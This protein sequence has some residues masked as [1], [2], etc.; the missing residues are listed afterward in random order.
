MW[1]P[2]LRLRIDGACGDRK[3]NRCPDGAGRPVDD[4]AC[5][6]QHGLGPLTDLTAVA[7]EDGFRIALEDRLQRAAQLHG[8]DLAGLARSQCLPLGRA[9]VARA[10]DFPQP[11]SVFVGDACAGHER[12]GGRLCIC[13]RR[14]DEPAFLLILRARDGRRI[15]ID[16]GETAVG[17]DERWIAEAQRE[18]VGLAQQHDQ[19]GLG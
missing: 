13:D 2:K 10:D 18:V 8:M 15:W 19:V 6:R 14:K 5:R 11:R 1:K 4:A 17:R 3:R 16:A 7:D 12:S 9:I